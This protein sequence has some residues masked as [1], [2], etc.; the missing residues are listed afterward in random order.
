MRMAGKTTVARLYAKFLA[1][2]QVIPSTMFV[3]TT[4]S[5][6]A[7]DGVPGTKKLIEDLV[8]NGGGTVFVDEAYQLTSGQNPLGGQVRTRAQRPYVSS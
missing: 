1:S 8:K 7:N 2:V 6:L 4:G 5:R 3:E